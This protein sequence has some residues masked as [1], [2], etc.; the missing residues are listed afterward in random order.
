M[1]VRRQNA[2][3]TLS[4]QRSGCSYTQTTP[5]T[6]SNPRRCT[7]LHAAARRCAPLHP[8][9]PSYAQLPAAESVV[10]SGA[11]QL[12][13]TGSH[14]AFSEERDFLRSWTAGGA[15]AANKTHLPARNYKLHPATRPPPGL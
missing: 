8:A 4:A 1:H 10:V 11:V 14:G 12:P 13:A 6:P 2:I 7:P 15:R 9:T 5:A 3:H